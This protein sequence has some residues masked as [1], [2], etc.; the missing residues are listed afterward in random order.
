MS[1]VTDDRALWLGRYV[2]PHEPALRAWL[3]RRRIGGLEPDDIIQEAYAKLVAI[4]TVEAIRDPRS[5]LFQIAK[6]VIATQLRGRKVVTI[7]VSDFDILDV[8]AEEPSAEDQLS[9]REELQRLAEAIAALPEPTRTIF[10]LR[11]I[12]QLPQRAI[13][14]QLR[15]PESTVEKHVSRAFLQMSNLLGRGG[16]RRV[17]ASKGRGQG[18]RVEDDAGDGTRD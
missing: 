18:Q 13:A 10:R 12:E 15:M 16:R 2:L 5:Y 7:G 3:A 11:R 4:P 9:D 6:S 8:A 1:K 17:F 14:A